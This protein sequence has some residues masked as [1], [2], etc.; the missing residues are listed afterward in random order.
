MAAKNAT[1]DYSRIIFYPGQ[2]YMIDHKWL[3]TDNTDD[4]API[5]NTPMLWNPSIKLATFSNFLVRCILI[6][7]WESYYK[8]LYFYNIYHFL[9]DGFNYL[10]FVRFYLLTIETIYV[11]RHPFSSIIG[12]YSLTF[13]TQF[14]PYF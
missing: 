9:P 4:N 2:L 7:I 6:N 12:T 11:D 1:L 3:N 8:I 13:D 5:C 14:L 10:N